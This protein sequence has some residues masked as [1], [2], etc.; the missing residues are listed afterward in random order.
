MNEFDDGQRHLP[1]LQKVRRLVCHCMGS[2][3]LAT[4][5]VH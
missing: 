5:Q 4:L 3:L 1:D 2:V